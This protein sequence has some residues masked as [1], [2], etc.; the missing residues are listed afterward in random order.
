MLLR[1]LCFALVAHGLPGMAQRHSLH[2]PC[3]MVLVGSGGLLHAGSLLLER[4]PVVFPSAPHDPQLLPR[5][6]RIAVG[7][8]DPAAH[9]MSNI[10]FASATGLSLVAAGLLSTG[11]RPL[12]PVVI[13]LE[14]GLLASGITNVVKELT[15]RP[16]PYL[17]DPLPAQGSL[18]GR[19]D[20]HAFWSGHVANI[21]AM[22]FST[23]WLVQRSD[24]SPASRTLV[25]SFAFAAPAAMAWLRVGAGRHFP[26]DVL[27][28]Y[29]FGS[30]VGWAVPYFHRRSVRGA[31]P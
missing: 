29:V 7:R 23:A 28:G 17:F 30:V 19:D 11:E 12:V 22:C 18:A 3:E 24:A 13:V 9:R 4:R 8:W 25:W 27:T 31:Q 1:A 6:D 10:L 16:R 21:S 5:M 2:G 20:H 14:S 15:H 26:T